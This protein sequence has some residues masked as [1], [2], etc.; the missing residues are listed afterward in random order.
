MEKKLWLEH[1]DQDTPSSLVDL[2]KYEKTL[3]EIE[4]QKAHKD[5]HIKWLKITLQKLKDYKKRFKEEER[6]DMLTTIEEDIKKVEEE[7]KALV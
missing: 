3:E 2:N 7:L 5:E 1:Y 6:E 4:Y